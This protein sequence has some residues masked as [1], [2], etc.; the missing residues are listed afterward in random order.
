[1]EV[2]PPMAQEPLVDGGRLVGREVVQ[3]DMHVEVLGDL[4]VHLV[5]KAMKSALVWRE[6]MSL[7]TRP[8]AISKAA[9]RSQVPLRW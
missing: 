4:A 5:Q 1:L 9:N 2:E 7:M 3:D 6:R 8:V